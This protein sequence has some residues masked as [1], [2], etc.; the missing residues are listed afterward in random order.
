MLPRREAAYS[1]EE[2]RKSASYKISKHDFF[3]T[4]LAQYEI[5]FKKGKASGKLVCFILYEIKYEE[6]CV[7]IM[8]KMVSSI[9]LN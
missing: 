5:A 7:A 3:E 2:G 4:Y 9:I 6:L 8:E 1:M